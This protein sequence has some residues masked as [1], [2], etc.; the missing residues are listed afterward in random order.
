[1]ALSESEPTDDDSQPHN[2]SKCDILSEKNS[3]K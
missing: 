2:H 1:M 3:S